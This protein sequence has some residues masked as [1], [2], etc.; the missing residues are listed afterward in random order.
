M[1]LLLRLL[2]PHFQEKYRFPETSPFKL[3]NKAKPK[4][5][6]VVPVERTTT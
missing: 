3:L 2:P 1:P 5:K 6:K 4:S